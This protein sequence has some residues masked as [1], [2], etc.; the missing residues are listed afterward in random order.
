VKK[1]A[2]VLN[3]ETRRQEKLRLVEDPNDADLDEGRIVLTGVSYSYP[4]PQLGLQKAVPV[5]D[6][7]VP[8]GNFVCFPEA[9]VGFNTLFQIMCRDLVPQTGR[10]LIPYQWRSIYIPVA[11]I[12][13]DG[14]LM[15]NLLFGDTNKTRESVWDICRAVGMSPEL[16]GQ[17]DYDVGSSGCTMKNSDKVLV[18]ITRALAHD[19]DMLMLSSALDVLG[20]SRA[21]K[22]LRFLRMYAARRGLPDERLPRELRRLKTVIY[23]S[24]YLVL[25][26]QANHHIVDTAT[27]SRDPSLS[28]VAEHLTVTFV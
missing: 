19:V 5:L 15:Y 18:S 28:L 22:V 25:Q 7:T 13:F 21:V 4:N 20:E 1:I 3:S 27:I 24:K 8:A 2:E 26:N 23:T 17:D 9:C 14:T 10:V 6:L 12:L 16:L 11:P